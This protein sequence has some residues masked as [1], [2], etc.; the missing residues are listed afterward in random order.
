M[1]RGL[2]VI[3]PPSLQLLLGVLGSNKLLLLQ[4]AEHDPGFERLLIPIGQT[5]WHSLK[6][7]R[8]ISMSVSLELTR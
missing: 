8:R 5:H 7:A 1:R 2:F 6:A 3:S 4:S